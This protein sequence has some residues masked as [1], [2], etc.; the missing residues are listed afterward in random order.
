MFQ[1]IHLLQNITKDYLTLY[2]SLELDMVLS[3]IVWRIEFQPYKDA[4]LFFPI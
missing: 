1:S 4:N 2:E 3:N